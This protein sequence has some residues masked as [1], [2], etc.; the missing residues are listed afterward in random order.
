MPRFSIIIP[1]RNRAHLLQYALQ[2][3]VAQT[4]D[5]FEVLVCDNNSQDETPSV[6]RGYCDGRVRYVRTDR[7]LPMPDNW[8]FALAQS[9]GEHVTYLPDDDALHPDLL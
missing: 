8:E 5:D 4:F 6:A 1:T 7:T 3:A 2:T 9:R